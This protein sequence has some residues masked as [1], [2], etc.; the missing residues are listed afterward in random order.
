M[1]LNINLLKKFVTV[2]DDQIQLRQLLDDLGLEVKD[3]SETIIDIETL[4]HRGDHLSAIGVAREI[5]ARNFTYMFHPNLDSELPVKKTSV[6]VY[7]NTKNCF[8][9]SLLEV[10]VPQDYKFVP[11][12]AGLE[13][14]GEEVIKLVNYIQLEMGQP[15]HAFDA[16]LLK[17]GI[18]IDETDSDKEII[19]LDG[20]AYRIPA[21][22]IVIRDREK[23]IAA[24]GVI[25]C[26]N[27]MVSSKT[28]RILVESASFDPVKVRITSKK[29]GLSTDAS[30]IFERGSDYQA[31]QTSLHRLLALGHNPY[32]SLQPLGFTTVSNPPEPKVFTIP[33]KLFEAH[34]GI[35]KID[36]ELLVKRLKLLG[37]E[38]A[39]QDKNIQA[40]PP[41]WRYWN[42]LTPMTVVEDYIR[43]TSYNSVKTTL[44][45]LQLEDPELDFENIFLDKTQNILLGNG[46]YEVIT[47]AYYSSEQAKLVGRYLGDLKHVA[48]A[49]SLEKGY[50][51]LRT[52][53]I[54]HFAE[55]INKNLK[56]GVNSVKIF[57][58]ANIFSDEN[59]E[60][61]ILSLA[62]GGR[63][64]E[65]EFKEKSLVDPLYLLQGLVF[66][67]LSSLD[68]SINIKNSKNPLLH[69]SKQ[70]EIVYKKKVLACLGEVHPSLIKDLDSSTFVFGEVY[71]D[72]V[73]EIPSTRNRNQ[74]S[75]FPVMKRDLTLKIPYQFLAADLNRII[76]SLEL[77]DLRKVEFIDDFK[78]SDE[79]FRRFTIRMI[80]QSLDQTLASATVDD[81]MAKV[82]ES[83]SKNGI[84]L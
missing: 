61:N 67:I 48:L 77:S 26:E 69:P 64:S 12:V 28:K 59:T 42:V 72:V 37:Y 27:S 17:G 22:S 9:Y 39:V 43:S 45:E 4:A 56:Y 75:D 65:L 34:S 23:I 81:Y 76:D 13:L 19:G 57:E 80:F 84:S 24:A 35:K 51:H 16:D 46:F 6:D 60:R 79:D 11:E 49:N 3:I 36:H 32:N 29:M 70:V 71:L 2:P 83:L 1:K 78:K 38:V 44:P 58:L 47:K 52:S 7:V 18:I 15:M 30:Y 31:P 10:A 55:V 20:K 50:S 53:H 54:A 8:N 5:A 62:V 82:C 41:S 40:T 33:I 14:E 74:Y 21:G 66:G 68:I 73:S 63:V 25:G